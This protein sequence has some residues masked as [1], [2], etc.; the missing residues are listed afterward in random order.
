VGPDLAE[1][2]KILGL[3]SATD[4]EKAAARRTAFLAS[5]TNTALSL[6][7]LFS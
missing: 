3:V 5:R 7:M 2:E 4:A 6:P 1:S